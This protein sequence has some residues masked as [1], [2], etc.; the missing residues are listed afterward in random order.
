MLNEQISRR[1]FLKASGGLVVT[2]AM[3]NRPAYAAAPP[4]GVKAKTVALDQVM[5]SSPSTGVAW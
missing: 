2:F 4:S 5:V 1:E 3:G